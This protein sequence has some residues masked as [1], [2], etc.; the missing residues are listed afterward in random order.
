MSVQE[1]L[2]EYFKKSLPEMKI[3]PAII[4]DICV[5]SS[6][7]SRVFFLVYSG[8]ADTAAAP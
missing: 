8:D 1:L 3:D 2:I 5:G 7:L 6:P 4:G